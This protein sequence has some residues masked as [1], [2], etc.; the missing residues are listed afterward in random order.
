MLQQVFHIL[1][2]LGGQQ[3]VDQT[4][5]HRELDIHHGT[6][7][8]GVLSVFIGDD[9][10]GLP[11]G[12]DRQNRCFW[13]IDDSSEIADAK[14]A[15]IGNGECAVAVLG[16][17][18]SAFLTTGY[19]VAGLGCYL[20]QCLFLYIFDYRHHKTIVT[21]HGVADIDGTVRHD[22][23]V[24]QGDVDAGE[25]LQRLAGGQC[26][27]VGDSD[28]HITVLVKLTAKFGKCSGVHRVGEV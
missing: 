19:Q 24:L 25:F 3:T 20:R 17:L 16:G 27:Q 1:H 26:Q 23:A 5:I 22:L 10:G 21:G 6:D 14:H 28:A 8:D 13:C 15:K 18:E 4:V 7:G 11:D 12:A 2:K 9:H